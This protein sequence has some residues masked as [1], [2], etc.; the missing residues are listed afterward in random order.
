MVPYSSL[1][2]IEHVFRVMG[3]SGAQKVTLNPEDGHV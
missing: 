1:N 2:Y 3:V